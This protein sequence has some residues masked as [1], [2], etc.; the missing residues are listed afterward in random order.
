MPV[1]QAVILC[2]GKGTRLGERAR[3]L[4]KPMLPVGGVRVL[5]HIMAC[6]ARGGVRRFVLSAG[7]LGQVIADVYAQS[8]IPGCTVETVIEETPRGTAGALHELGG[9]LDEEF[10]VAYGDVFM[11]FDTGALLA[12]HERHRPACT[13]LVRASDHPEDSHLVVADEAGRV[14]EFVHRREPGRRYRNVANAG[15]Y[16]LNRRVLDFVPEGR[17]TDFGAD[18]FPALLACGEVVCAHALEAEGYVKDMGTPVRLAQVEEFI[19]DRAAAETARA[20]PRALTTV[21]LDR[22][23]VLNREAGLIGNPEGLVVLPGAGEAVA[24]LNRLGL[25]C[26]VVTNQPVIARGLCDEETLARIHERLREEIAA[27]GGKLAAIYHCPHHPETHH[28]EGGNVELRRACRCRKP[29]PGMIFK[30]MRELN[31]DLAGAVIVG[32]RATDIRAGRAAGIRTVLVGDEASRARERTTCKPD[33]EYDSLLA[34]ARAL[35]EREVFSR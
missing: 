32:D 30:A 3:T 4:P 25:R 9:L 10:V 8:P 17:P 7:Y 16:V 1:T 31:V 6:L 26:V 33:A 13:L 35:S 11:D 18:I 27:A 29:S 19:T 12:A 21:F 15:V 28:D 14:T 22:D 20:N 5:D 2:G 24:L 34:F 23:G